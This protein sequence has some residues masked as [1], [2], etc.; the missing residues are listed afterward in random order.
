MELTQDDWDQ[1]KANPVTK[2]VWQIL[3]ERQTKIA[4][5]LANGGALIAGE[6]EVMVGRYR[7]IDDLLTMNFEDTKQEKEE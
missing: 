1:W 5:G 3:R 2:E 6:R 4:H 7:E